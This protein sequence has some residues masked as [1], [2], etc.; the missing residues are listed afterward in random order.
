MNHRIIL[1]VVYWCVFSLHFRRLLGIDALGPLDL[2]IA[3][4]VVVMDDCIALGFLMVLDDVG[5]VVENCRWSMYLRCWFIYVYVHTYI[6]TY[7]YIYIYTC[8]FIS[9]RRKWFV[10]WVDYITFD[11][12]NISRLFFV[13]DGF[14]DR[15]YW[16]ESYYVYL[17]DIRYVLAR[18]LLG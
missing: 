3:L 11:V 8:L 2:W 18:V 15:K 10:E 5:V 6:H 4:N 9:S 13:M 14:S 16:V 7:I 12:F 17:D 1:C